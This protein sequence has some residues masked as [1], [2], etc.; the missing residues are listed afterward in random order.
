MTK[1]FCV[2]PFYGREIV[3]NGHQTHCCL[4]PHGHDIQKV[5]TEMING[6]RPV[7]CQKCWSLEDQGLQSDRQLKNS[8]LDVYWDRDIESIAQDA[9]DGDDRIMML[10]LFTSY[11][12]NATC[13]ICDS[14]NSSAWNKIERRMDKTIPIKSYQFIDI[15]YVKQQVDFRELKM[16]SLIGGEP[17]YE[18]RNFELLEHILELGNNT[19]FLSMVTNGSVKLTSRQK[20]ILS[21]FKNL[22]FCVSIDG[23]GPVFEY[24][25]FPL[26]WQDLTDNLKFFREL[27]DNISSNYSLSN[28]NILYH[29]ETVKWFND[30]NLPFTTQPIYTPTW[31][32]P[33]ALSIQAK[34][35]LKQQLNDVD[36][37]AY[38][39][40]THTAQDQ[41]N[42]E[43]FLKN[44][45]KQ[46]QAKNIHI[47]DYVPELAD[48]V[49]L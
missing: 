33:R 18:K 3:W 17:L 2:L 20:T 19:V 30:T 47:R 32:Q 25:R 34:Q 14:V 4:L 11:T 39:G 42:F 40:D 29:N 12:C 10:K 26:K 7:E 1:N 31:L 16:L 6:Q 13:I 49:G 46:D 28:V 22:N 24:T 37:N 9:K 21:K 41:Q 35:V 8:A 44:I 15:D 23:T 43:L 36:Y 5:K 45:V 48:L 27:T 38:I